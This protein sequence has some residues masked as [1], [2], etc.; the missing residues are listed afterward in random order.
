MFDNPGYCSFGKLLSLGDNESYYPG[1]QSYVPVTKRFWEIGLESKCQNTNFLLMFLLFYS[2]S[3]FL[4]LS[5]PYFV[6]H[7]YLCSFAVQVKIKDGNYCG[8]VPVFLPAG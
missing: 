1:I 7:V 6:D 8:F 3:M 2:S 4:C 5:L